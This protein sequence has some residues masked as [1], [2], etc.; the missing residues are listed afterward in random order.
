[1][2]LM[3]SICKKAKFLNI[4]IKPNYLKPIHKFDGERNDNCQEKELA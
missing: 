3:S 2:K 1:M 4:Q